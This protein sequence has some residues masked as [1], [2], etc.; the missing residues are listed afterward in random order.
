[1]LYL[2][3]GER[4]DKQEWARRLAK[5][6]YKSNLLENDFGNWLIT[7]YG[8]IEIEGL[9]FSPQSILETLEY[10]SYMSYH[11]QYCENYVGDIIKN[12]LDFDKIIN[13]E[14]FV[15]KKEAL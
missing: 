8:I 1:M 14:T 9:E 6:F 15:A 12:D 2:H 4:I 3:K 7:R 13:G 5:V 11:L 10:S